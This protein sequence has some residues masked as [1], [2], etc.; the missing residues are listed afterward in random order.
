[1]SEEANTGGTTDIQGIL[2]K[3]VIEATGLCGIF[4]IVEITEGCNHER[5]QN[6][7]RV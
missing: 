1:M 6:T 5:D 4:L 2:E 3:G 7:T